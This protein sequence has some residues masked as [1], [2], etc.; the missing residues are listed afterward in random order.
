H[1]QFDDSQIIGALIAKWRVDELV[2]M[3][4]AEV[5]ADVAPASHR[6]L[7]RRD[8]IILS[9]PRAG[10]DVAFQVNRLAGGSTAA[11]DA[12]HGGAGYLLE[13]DER[14]VRSLVGYAGSKGHRSFTGLG[15]SVLVA[16]DAKTA[17]AAIER[18]KLLTLGL[19]ALAA[20]VVAVV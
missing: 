11:A 19:A 13:P 6:L 18:V 12:A 15:W 7:L 9:A 5:G 8:G 1:A 3:L 10:Q 16:Q 17:F 4:G 2:R 14:G 20:L